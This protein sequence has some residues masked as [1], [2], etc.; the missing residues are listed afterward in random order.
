[1]AE[2]IKTALEM[3][4]AERI[5][6]HEALYDYLANH[7]VGYWSSSFLKRLLAVETIDLHWTSRY[8]AYQPGVKAS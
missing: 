8:S 1:M 4:R 7:D 6:R 2:A 5:A 3:P